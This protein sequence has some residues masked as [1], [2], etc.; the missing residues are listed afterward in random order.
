MAC[1]RKFGH[2]ANSLKNLQTIG[3]P[4]RLMMYIRQS[5]TPNLNVVKL[6]REEIF[7]VNVLA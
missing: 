4:D 2:I 1:D 6:R 3:S 5:Q 7:N